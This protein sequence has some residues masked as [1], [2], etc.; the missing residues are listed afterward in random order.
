MLLRLRVLLLLLFILVGHV[1]W[2]NI[3]SVF[4]GWNPIWSVLLSL[5]FLVAFVLR[6]AQIEGV[7][8]L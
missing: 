6:A 8:A 3:N 4:A 1:D 2:A 7:H 5:A